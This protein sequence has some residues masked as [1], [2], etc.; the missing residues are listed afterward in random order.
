VHVADGDRLD[1]GGLEPGGER[2]PSVT[3][4]AVL[5]PLRS[6]MALVAR[7]VPWMIR[8]RSAGFTP[9][10]FRMSAT[11]VSTPSSGARGV[12][13]TFT[14][15]RLPFHS[16]QRSVKVPPMSTASFAFSIAYAAVCL[17]LPPR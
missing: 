14:L 2:K 8:P 3:T 17:M 4:S 5:A 9:D 7:V 12:V 16:R 1:A 6:M 15:V 10:S 13:S 11:P